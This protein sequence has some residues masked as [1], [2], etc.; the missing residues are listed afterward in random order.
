[1]DVLALIWIESHTWM[2]LCHSL[3]TVSML[4]QT[5]S[6]GKPTPS[7]VEALIIYYIDTA[8]LTL[9]QC[10]CEQLVVWEWVQLRDMP[11]M[12]REREIF[13]CSSWWLPWK[14]SMIT[15]R[16]MVSR[17]CSNHLVCRNIVSIENWCSDFGQVLPS[18]HACKGGRPDR[19]IKSHF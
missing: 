13:V 15:D 18:M 7:I 6:K 3:L 19:L 4:H 14:G 11:W 5:G 12:W 1:M 10:S 17:N 8:F 2:M 16:K 9:N